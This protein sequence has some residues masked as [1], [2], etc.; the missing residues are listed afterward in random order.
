MAKSS[1]KTPM[2]DATAHLPPDDLED[3]A[4]WRRRLRESEGKLAGLAA[5][6]REEIAR[7][8]VLDEDPATAR[9]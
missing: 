9:G 3:E 6:V 8:E 7:G 1:D 2:G 5:M 4:R